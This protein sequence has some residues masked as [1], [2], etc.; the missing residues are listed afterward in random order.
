LLGFFFGLSW[1]SESSFLARA[2]YSVGLG[3]MLHV[4]S[5]IAYFVVGYAVARLMN[6]STEADSIAPD[7]ARLTATLTLAI[8]VWILGHVWTEQRIDR[9]ATCVEDPQVMANAR[10]H[11]SAG[12]LIRW[13]STEYAFD[14]SSPLDEDF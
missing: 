6:E 12:A 4:A 14:D 13:C 2:G 5:L 3:F 10:V 7:D 11:G 1:F 9:I 8:A